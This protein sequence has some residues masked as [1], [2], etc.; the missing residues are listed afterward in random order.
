MH[1]YPL[2][3][4]QLSLLLLTKVGLHLE[5]PSGISHLPLVILIIEGSIRTEG[6][7]FL[8]IIRL[9]LVS[10]HIFKLTSLV[11]KIL[12]FPLSSID[13]LER[14][15]VAL[16]LAIRSETVSGLLLTLRLLT[17]LHRID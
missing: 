2:S 12:M 5:V 11:I 16:I 10:H 15:A 14:L 6:S 17:K 9:H 1:D 4:E 13:I 7:L 3:V 8:G